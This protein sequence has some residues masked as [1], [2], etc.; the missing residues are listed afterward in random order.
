MASALLC[1]V[2]AGFEGQRLLTAKI[3][4]NAKKTKIAG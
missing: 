3:A 2:P 4:K 1:G